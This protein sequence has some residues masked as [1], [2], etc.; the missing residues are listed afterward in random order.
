[1]QA[2]VGGSLRGILLVPN[3]DSLLECSGAQMRRLMVKDLIKRQKVQ[4]ALLQETKLR[5]ISDSIVSQVLWGLRGK[6]RHV[7]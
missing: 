3:E 1:M 6:G 4:T 5:E 2:R 7:K